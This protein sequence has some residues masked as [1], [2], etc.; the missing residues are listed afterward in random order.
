MDWIELVTKGDVPGGVTDD[1]VVCFDGNSDAVSMLIFADWPKMG[2]LDEDGGA[3]EPGAAPL[4]E[5][6]PGSPVTTGAS[7]CACN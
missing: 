3:I 1:V 5:L 6:R 7:I 4:D 2:A